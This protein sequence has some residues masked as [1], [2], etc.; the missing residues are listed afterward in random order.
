MKLPSW[1]FIVLSY[2][3]L[4]L[5]IAAW[6]L[7]DPLFGKTENTPYPPDKESIAHYGCTCSLTE[8]KIN[9]LWWDTTVWVEYRDNRPRWT[10]LFAKHYA[11]ERTKAIH[12]CD[13]WLSL[14]APIKKA[15]K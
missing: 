12:E 9:Q 2:L 10:H 4:A 11:T 14:V 7:N 13:V 1:T 6:L 8:D 3:A 15:E 5:F